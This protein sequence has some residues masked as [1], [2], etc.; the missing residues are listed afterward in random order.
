MLAVCRGEQGFNVAMGGGL[1][2]DVPTYLGE[3]VKAGKI[4]EDRAT[5]IEDTGIGWG[6]NKKPCDTPHYRVTVDGLVHSGGNGLF[7]RIA[8]FASGLGG[9]AVLQDSQHATASSR[10]PYSSASS[11]IAAVCPAT[12]AENL[13]P[14]NPNRAG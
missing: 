13:P 8:P 10:M 7:R 4:A 12:T 11:S 3:Q 2:Q 5:V 9:H 1:I 14:Q 6:D